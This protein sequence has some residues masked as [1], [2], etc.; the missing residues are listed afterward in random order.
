VSVGAT[1]AT[2]TQALPAKRACARAG[3]GPVGC[4]D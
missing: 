1:A 2:V 4:A 3:A